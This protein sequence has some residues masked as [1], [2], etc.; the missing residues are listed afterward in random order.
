[1]NSDVIK[2]K[3]DLY[4][5]ILFVLILAITAVISVAFNQI[6]DK[7]LNSSTPV[8]KSNLTFHAPLY[9]KDQKVYLIS[10]S[11]TAS[12][13]AKHGSS[14]QNYAKSIKNFGLF[15][16]KIGFDTSIVSIDSIHSLPP[17]SILF[18][19]DAQVLSDQEKK[20]LL[21]FLENGGSIFFNFTSGFNNTKDQYTGDSFVSQITKLK[22]SPKGF[23]QFKS[24]L[25]FTPR[26]LSPLNEYLKEGKWSYVPLYDKIPIYN[27]NNFQKADL[28]MTNYSQTSAPMA[29]GVKNQLNNSESGLI[30]HG[31]LGRGKWIYSSLPSYSFYDSDENQNEYAKL[32]IGMIKFLKDKAI[33]RPFPYID[34]R[35]LVFVSEDTEYKFEN[36][37]RFADLAYEYKVPVT[38]FIVAGL[39]QL[40]EHKQMMQKIAKNRF[41]EFASHSTSHKKIIGMSP[42]FVK[43]ETIGSKKIIDRFALKPIIGFRPPREELDLLMK[44]YLTEGGFAYILGETKSYL[45]P[46]VDKDVKR[47]YF[48]PRHGTDDYTF[49][50]NLDWDQKQIVQQIINE[51]EFVHNLDGIYTLSVHTHLFSYSSNINIIRSF[52]KYLKSHPYLKPLQGR[53]IIKKV[54]LYKHMNFETLMRGDELKIIV[55][56]NNQ[57]PVSN[58]HFQLF[59]NPNISI[60]G[61]QVEGV[62][63]VKVD[64]VDDEVILDRLAPHSKTVVSIKLRG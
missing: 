28:F 18:L 2:K 19:L 17:K 53:Q 61:G 4:G 58:L 40:P 41:V 12:F 34:E 60:V 3:S 48:M 9:L 31:Y 59:K 37:Q 13:Y 63:S 21:S 24:G 1:M 55:T 15:L 33:A 16:S 62:N 42:N 14:A 46:T 64:V 26:L 25:S 32:L 54:D 47:L 29:K 45:Y 35:S 39:A 7:S 23:A 52:F 51:A 38:A 10:S 49:L 36:F 11:N 5:Y 30:W 27:T 22:L 57:T 50:V 56:N 44:R 43:K 8:S 20:D 6:N